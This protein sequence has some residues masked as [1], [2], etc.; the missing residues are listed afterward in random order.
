MRRIYYV[1]GSV[2]VGD[3][4]CKAVLRYARALSKQTLSDVVSIPFVS[5]SGQKAYAHLLIGPA[6]QLF[7]TPVEGTP[8]ESEDKDVLKELERKTKALQPDR[9]TWDQEMTDVPSLED[10]LG[11][12]DGMGKTV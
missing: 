3:R 11:I 10:Y 1:S 4:T 12:P 7:S 6:S 9:P 5:E 8:D 2:V